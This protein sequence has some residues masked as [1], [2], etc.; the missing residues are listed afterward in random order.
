MGSLTRRTRSNDQTHRAHR[1]RAE[2]THGT[3]GR[4][5]RARAEIRKNRPASRFDPD[6]AGRKAH[7]VTVTLRTVRRR[8]VR[9][10]L[11][12]SRDAEG[13]PRRPR[14][15]LL[16]AR[17]RVL[18]P[19]GRRRPQGEAVRQHPRDDR[20]DPDREDQPPRARGDQPLREGRVLQ[21]LLLR[22]G[23]VRARDHPA[24]R[25]NPP[26]RVPISAAA[27]SR[28]PARGAFPSRPPSSP[29][30]SSD[31]PTPEPNTPLRT[32]PRRRSLPI[33]ASPSQ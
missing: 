1:T 6:V 11:P 28:G 13:R 9:A 7:V 30:P 8:H 21:P 3:R 16:Q 18:A 4:S 26:R 33:A 32:K 2:A 31:G 14:S 22:Q 5:T 25:S 12:R 20:A 10:H 23:S 19:R 27:P 17:R 15:A 24:R 29:V